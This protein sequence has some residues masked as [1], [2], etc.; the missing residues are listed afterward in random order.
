[1]LN[2]HNRGE[3]IDHKEWNALSTLSSISIVGPIIKKLKNYLIGLSKK[4]HIDLFPIKLASIFNNTGSDLKCFS[5]VCLGNAL[6]DLD[7]ENELIFE[8]D[9]NIHT[10]I[11]VCL[12][13][14]P[15]QS[16]GYAAIDGICPV[17]LYNRFKLDLL[18]S[19]SIIK[20]MSISTNNI[21]G[22]LRIIWEEDVNILTEHIG[23]VQFCNYNY[24]KSV[25]S[26]NII[27]FG[28]PLTVNPTTPLVDGRLNLDIIDND[29]PF[30]SVF[31]STDDVEPMT[32]F[33]SM[34][35]SDPFIGVLNDEPDIHD[36]NGCKAM[37]DGFDMDYY[38]ATHKVI[39][40]LGLYN[41]LH[42]GV[43][44]V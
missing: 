33:L 4:S 32:S 22:P 9:N 35:S 36:Y 30:S 11:A 1:M 18:K 8:I 27:P 39:A 19:A 13:P 21:T 3:I 15:D 12:E 44:K 7:V 23:I 17:N 37:E 42:Y 6:A 31:I 24:I 5:T 16:I 25:S 40:Y 26:S 14:I 41:S 20:N 28:F 43:I 38:Q 2:Y 34:N 29:I 10:S